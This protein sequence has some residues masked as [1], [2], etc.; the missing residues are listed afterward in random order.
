MKRKNF[1]I[2][3]T[4]LL[5]SVL[6]AAGG[7]AAYMQS[8]YYRIQDFDSLESGGAPKES[9]PLCCGVPYSAMTYNIGFGA[10]NPEFSFFMDQGTM[11][12]G[13]VVRGK[14]ARAQSSAIVKSNTQGAVRALQAQHADFYLL[15]EVDRKATRSFGIDQSAVAAAALPEY[16]TVFASN[17]HSPYLLYP[18]HEPHGSVESGLLLLSRYNISVAVRRSYPVNES[19]FS[20][21]FDLDRA[22]VLLRIPVENGKELVLINSHMSAYDKGGTVRARQLALLNSV[23]AEERALGNYVLAG[24]DFNHALGGSERAFASKQQFPGWVYTL[25][26]TDLAEGYRVVLAD[27]IYKVATCRSSEIPY[28]AGVG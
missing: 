21:F 24:G 9:A 16:A 19:F 4:A 5:G 14:H 27:N 26:D 28:T 15:Q 2:G 10:Y 11:A 13:T 7:Y 23:L 12:D 3:C 6:L 1:A 20:R 18:F 22:F 25:K 17:F 8:H